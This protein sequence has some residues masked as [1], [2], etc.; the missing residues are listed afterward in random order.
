[1]VRKGKIEPI[2]EGVKMDI[3]EL[4]EYERKEEEGAT[5]IYREIHSKR[6]ISIKDC[7]PNLKLKNPYGAYLMG[8]PQSI[9]FLETHIVNISSF[10]DKDTFEKAYGMSVELLIEL[11]NK[12]KGRVEFLLNGLPTEFA[13][14]DYLDEILE[15]KPPSV[16]CRTPLYDELSFGEDKISFYAKEAY[17]V[18]QKV[19]SSKGFEEYASPEET[20]KDYVWNS[21]ERLGIHGYDYLIKAALKYAESID[22]EMVSNELMNPPDLIATMCILYS[23]FLTEP[24]YSSLDGVHSLDSGAG[25]IKSIY[26]EALKMHPKSRAELFSVDV[27]KALIEACEIY[28][29]QKQNIEGI[30]DLDIEAKRT[31]KALKSLDEAVKKEQVDKI[32]DR[33]RALRNAIVDTHEAVKSTEKTKDNIEKAINYGSLTVGIVGPIVSQITTENFLFSILFGSLGLSTKFSKIATPVAEVL[34][35]LKKPNHVVMIYEI[36]KRYKK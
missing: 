9:P 4:E 6:K 16:S 3:K 17:K 22:R 34:A 31:R 13:N 14:L 7:Y 20:L 29:P 32:V 19:K 1:M 28:L 35:K 33:K 15:F 23:E 2:D 5:E 26:D 30:L 21:Y 36:K 12:G 11:Y 24:I 8:T 10:K 25:K 27:G 18:I